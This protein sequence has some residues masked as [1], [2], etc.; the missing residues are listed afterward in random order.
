MDIYRITALGLIGA[1]LSVTLKKDSP[2]LAMAVSIITSVL[3]LIFFLP[4]MGTVFRTLEKIDGLLSGEGAYVKLI[5]KIVAVGYISSFGAKI[6][7]DFGESSVGHKIEL[8][9]KLII[10]IFS[11]PVISGLID[12]LKELMP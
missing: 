10:L 2:Q 1:V 9:G 4:E 12:M 5:L 7:E 3:I 11:L 6:C 8:G